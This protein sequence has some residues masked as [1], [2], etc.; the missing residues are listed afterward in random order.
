MAYPLRKAFDTDFLTSFPLEDNARHARKENSPKTGNRFVIEELLNKNIPIFLPTKSYLP[1]YTIAPPLFKEG[2]NFFSRFENG[3]LKKAIRV[4]R[5]EYELHLS[6]DYNTNGHYHWF[7]FKTTSTLPANTPVHFAIVNMLK[8]RSLYN[9]GLRPFAFSVKENKGWRPAGENVVYTP[10]EN[11]GHHSLKW[12]YTYQFE[13]DEVYFAQFVPYTYSDL[14]Q[15]LREIKGKSE[16]VRMERLC[17]TLARNV[18]PVLTITEDVATFL[19]YHYERELMG[20][21]KVAKRTVLNS[22]GALRRKAK[23]EQADTAKFHELEGESRDLTQ[24][25]QRHREDHG[26]KKGVIITARVHPGTFLLL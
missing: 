17:K 8:R 19:P 18:C 22:V 20:K 21:S 4:S 14:L 11:E 6:E 10:A 7:Y 12:S 9:A 1:E 16:V 5:T 3:N 15:H 24:A 2:I 23:N 25:L 13:N 26:R